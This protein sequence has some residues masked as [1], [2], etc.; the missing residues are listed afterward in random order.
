MPIDFSKGQGL[1]MLLLI[2]A[3]V[4]GIVLFTIYKSKKKKYLGRI[5]LP[6]FFIELSVLFLIMTLSFHKRDEIGP[7]VVPRLWIAILIALNIYLIIRTLLDKDEPDPKFG[8]IDTVLLF[9]GIVVV[10]LILTPLIGYFISTFI[11]LFIGMY[12]LSYK[13]IVTMVTIS[14]GW[15]LFSYLIFFKLLYVPLPQGRLIEAIFR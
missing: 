9:F 12:V 10:Y 1:V 7:S 8:R 5:A 6:L 2:L 13:K 3:A 4:F 14:G 11:F 15:L